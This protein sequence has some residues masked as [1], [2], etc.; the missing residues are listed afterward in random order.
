MGASF[1][2]KWLGLFCLE[3]DKSILNESDE[4]FAVFEL[5]LHD[6]D[7]VPDLNLQLRVVSYGLVEGGVV[8]EVPLVLVIVLVFVQV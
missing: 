7:P 6:P 5:T 8:E 4:A 1:D 3:S 2:L